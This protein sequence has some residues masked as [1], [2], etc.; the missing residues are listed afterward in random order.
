MIPDDNDV[1]VTI[2]DSDLLMRVAEKQDREA[3]ARLFKSIA[4]RIKGY[5]MKLGARPEAAEEIAQETLITVWRKAG[6]FDRQKSSAVTWIF[7]IARNLC[8]DRLR[9][10]NRPALDPNE[11]LLVPDTPRSPLAEFEES[12][13][14]DRVT[15]AIEKLPADQQEAV[16]LSFIEGL[17]HGEISKRLNVPLGTIK[18]RLRLAFEKLR[19]LLGDIR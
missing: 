8:I 6:Q 17:S 1:P 2:S 19:L 3:F 4:P 9:K 11:P 12:T 15:A 13:V 7:T 5:M 10:E 18:S 16:R 14:V